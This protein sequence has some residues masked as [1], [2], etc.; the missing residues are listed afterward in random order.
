MSEQNSQSGIGVYSNSA[1][2]DIF[3]SHNSHLADQAIQLYNVLNQINPNWNIF[4]DREGGFDAAEQN[5]AHQNISIDR[6]KFLIFVADSADEV[7]KSG[8]G[9]MRGE[10][11]RFKDRSERRMW[12]NP[13][14]NIAF[15]GIFLCDRV[16]FNDPD[17]IFTVGNTNHIVL[18]KDAN[19]TD[20]KQL[21]EK[22]IVAARFNNPSLIAQD[23]ASYVLGQVKSYY[24]ANVDFFTTEDYINTTF[25]P[26]KGETK[27]NV[28][29]KELT[30]HIKQNNTI[31]LGEDGGIGKTT[32]L[33]TLFASFLDLN[34]TL[35]E[36]QFVPVFVEA[37]RILSIKEYLDNSL[38]AEEDN[39]FVRYIEQITMATRFENSAFKDFKGSFTRTSENNTKQYLFL[40][41]GLNEIP[42]SYRAKIL[43]H[44]KGLCTF[45][46]CR[47]VAA[48]RDISDSLEA[49]F[50][51]IYKIN[52]ITK[53]DVKQYL[54]LHYKSLYS[55]DKTLYKILQIP[56]YLKIYC[57]S[58]DKNLLNKGELLNGFLKQQFSASKNKKAAIDDI[59][60]LIILHHLLPYIAYNMV[61]NEA[62][63]ITEAEL[64]SKVKEYCES[65]AN[66]E[67]FLDYYDNEFTQRFDVSFTDY[68]AEILD[69][70]SG[71]NVIQRKKYMGVFKAFAV[72][73]L[74][75]LRQ[76]EVN[77]Q[78]GLEFSHQIYRDFFCARYIYEN[79]KLFGLIKHGEVFNIFTAKNYEKDIRDFTSDLFIKTGKPYY[80]KEDGEWDYSC[81]KNNPLIKALD[82]LRNSQNPNAAFVV[83]NIVYIL[84]GVREKDL[85]NLDFSELNLSQSN[86]KTAIF[87]RI[88][89][90]KNYCTSF[91]NAKLNLSNLYSE[92]VFSYLTAACICKDKIATLDLGNNL[93]LWSR[94]MYNSTP[95]LSLYG[96]FEGI[97]K[98]IFS[99]C[100]QFIYAKSVDKIFKI[101]YQNGLTQQIIYSSNEPLKDIFTQNG[102]VYFTTLFNP[103]NPKS[104]TNPTEPDTV[105]FRC[106]NGSADINES[107][108]TAIF[109]ENAVFDNFKMYKNTTDG[110]Q[111]EKIAYPLL[112]DEY[113]V[114]ME[115]TLKK[116]DL[117]KMFPND[118]YN[119]NS[120]RKQYFVSKQHKFTDRNHDW[121][122]API[123]ITAEILKY[124]TEKGAKL[125]LEFDKELEVLTN[126]YSQ[127][128][129]DATHKNPLAMR[130]FGKR[131]LSV[132][133]ATNS[134]NFLL[135]LYQQYTRADL[136]RVTTWTVCEF[137]PKTLTMREID[138][139]SG[140]QKIKAQYNG[141]EIV[142]L[143]PMAVSF[144]D[145]D[146]NLIRMFKTKTKKIYGIINHPYNRTFFAVSANFV[147]EISYDTAK[148]IRCIP[149]TCIYR[150]KFGYVKEKETG[151]IIGIRIGYPEN[152]GA[153]RAQS[154]ANKEA[155]L[156]L[157]LNMYMKLIPV[158]RENY[159]YATNVN[160]S[161]PSIQMG[162]M[163]NIQV[164]ATND[165]IIFYKD[166][167]KINN[168]PN[169]YK[170][171]IA[172]CDFTGVSGDISCTEQGQ[173]IL[174]SYGAKVDFNVIEN[175]NDQ[176]A[177]LSDSIPFNKIALPQ[178]PSTNAVFKFRA[179]I[180][181][182][183]DQENVSV[184]M[185]DADN[186]SK[187]ELRLTVA[188]YQNYN[189][190]HAD[191]LLLYW[192]YMLK[193]V[194]LNVLNRIVL[195]TLAQN[196]HCPE[197]TCPK[198]IVHK[199]RFLGKKLGLVNLYRINMGEFEHKV[200]TIST[201]YGQRFLTNL[202]NANYEVFAQIQKFDNMRRGD[203]VKALAFNE[204][205]SKVYT[206]NQERFE[207]ITFAPFLDADECD[208]RANV[209]A[210][211]K[212]KHAH[213]ITF[214]VRRHYTTD[215]AA[216][217]YLRIKTIAETK[218]F[219]N[220]DKTKQRFNNP[221]IIMIC[222]D[223]ERCCQIRDNLLARGVTKLPLFSYDSLVFSDDNVEMFE[224]SNPENQGMQII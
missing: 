194:D 9:R 116:Y 214:A 154:K 79:I 193:F 50:K 131:I 43:E 223:Y 168:I 109:A 209:E 161:A 165:D 157:D 55:V 77:G 160:G 1:E 53:D 34:S 170:L 88:V 187:Q 114:K 129:L 73:K 203:V 196:G 206:N 90:D 29:L 132:D 65:V 221:Q 74:K 37:N 16:D 151:K 94:D 20:Y 63:E 122:N 224:F 219:V 212:T 166:S 59:P 113:F 69:L 11:A 22:A 103:F 115:D 211:F 12:L 106:L 183:V 72:S 35:A 133:A 38:G 155:I 181:K 184:Q 84:S 10:V 172:G 175:K 174:L 40:I 70:V 5:D 149:C 195:T 8:Y 189:F 86:L 178:M 141:N 21:I 46:N 120:D 89:G 58:E 6:S 180:S 179:D 32:L 146:K 192:M 208:G 210:I 23:Y 112:L 60:N 222:E 44:L 204:W 91:K 145:S 152:T 135:S 56:M 138:Y 98:I 121:H 52:P 83:R 216:D 147:Y 97:N 199:L 169:C 105:E 162:N 127:K 117:Y 64:Y 25:K 217:K 57:T 144:Y 36:P 28:D 15:F 123:R 93:M 17:N 215:K 197:I 54:K 68:I 163:D 81:N 140:S 39:I 49:E 61:L 143:T 80:N 124:L 150:A 104:I 182:T 136:S 30:E 173:K 19:I 177:L 33:K 85:T 92:T 45:A 119:T 3:I 107:A 14:Y 71:T 218:G 24:S 190:D 188:N 4:L 47:V 41:D 111:E 205:F 2:Y 78:T 125:E 142:A 220:V 102:E 153:K 118:A 110:W 164:K 95:I 26:T 128:I 134:D 130:L 213:Y 159:D 207:K 75:L 48:T 66:D 198:D 126:E 158:D 186:V 27:E 100:G 13:N 87:S 148:V 99:P 191:F 67:Q 51:Q 42:S 76:S 18:G 108:D 200:Y 139:N 82:N 167:E 185:L 31:I 176:T 7:N 101:E 202:I 156:F 201:G 171:F 96:D 137:N 62:F